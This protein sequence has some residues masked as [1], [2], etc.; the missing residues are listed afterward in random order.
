L[1]IGNSHSQ[2]SDS[3]LSTNSLQA[4]GHRAAN[5]KP[6]STKWRKRPI[7]A[8]TLAQREDTTYSHETISKPHND[9]R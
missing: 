5:T 9:V 7:L 2:P 8:C 3:E 1:V 6:L 4:R